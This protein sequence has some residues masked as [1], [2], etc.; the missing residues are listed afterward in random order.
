M[1]MRSLRSK[2]L[3]VLL[4]VTLLL[5][6][7]SVALAEGYWTSYLSGVNRGY[8][9]R[10]WRDYHNDSASTWV[11]FA[12]C[13]DRD[14]NTSSDQVWATLILWRHAGIFPPEDKGHIAKYCYYGASFN[15]GVQPGPAEDFHWQVNDFSGGSGGNRLDVNH[16]TTY[17]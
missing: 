6:S 8:N 16:L 12:D 7:A 1:R 11:Y 9:S 3:G 15:W 10:T 13:N 5:V 14:P 4:G 17:Y 2:W